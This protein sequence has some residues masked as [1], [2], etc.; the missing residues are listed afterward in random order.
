MAAT[1]TATKTKKTKQLSAEDLISAYKD[2]TLTHG[3]P[4]VSVFLFTKEL[5][6]PESTFY[7]HFGSFDA[8]EKHLWKQYVTDVIEAIKS[9]TTYEE[10]GTRE[11]LL[12]FYFALFEH[13][14]KD[15]SYLV[16]SLRMDKNMPTGLS[17]FR[18]VRDAF[19]HFVE[20]LIVDG[21]DNGEIEQRPIIGERY[22]D[23]L[24][25]QFVFL[26]GFWLKDD[27]ARFEKTDAAVEKSVNL[28]FE[29]MSSG[30]LDQLIDFT[31][32]IWQNR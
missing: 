14:R 21:I 29:L 3:H 4:P 23:G 12:S 27:S 31:K 10:Y 2:Y 24:W 18:P 19:L 5:K 17:G 9:D 16:H 7:D 32:F 26:I 30:P 15:R 28:A 22:K 1:K 11:R 25:V 6:I 20:E 13:L 8:L